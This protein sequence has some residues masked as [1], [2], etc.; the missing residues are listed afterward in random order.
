MIVGVAQWVGRDQD[1][2]RALD[3]VSI[4]E[5]VARDA[6]KDAGVGSRGLEALDRIAVPAIL[7][8]RVRNPAHRLAE[9]L[10]CHPR[11]EIRTSIGGNMPQRLVNET[12]R[13]VLEGRSE[14]ALIA[15]A[16]AQAS[17]QR[18]RRARIALDWPTSDEPERTVVGDRRPGA[19]EAETAH[20]I[21]LPAFVYPLF[22]NA[23]RARRG[24]SLAEHR[25]RLGRLCSRW[26][27]VAAENPYAWFPKRRSPEEITEPTAENRWIAFPY[28]KFMNAILAVDQGAALLL[29]SRG[30]ARAWGIPEERLVYWWGGGDAVQEPWFVSDRERFDASPALARAARGALAEA[31]VGVEELDFLDLYSCFPSSVEIACQELG[32][33]LDDPRPPTV[34]GGLP[35]AGGPGNNYTT[36]AVA[37]LVERLRRK[38]GARGLVTGLGWYLSRHS[39]GVYAS[40]PPER[41]EPRHPD[42]PAAGDFARPLDPDAAGEGRVETYTVLFARDGTPERGVVLGRLDGGRRFLAHTPSDPTL[43]EDLVRREVVGLRG[44]V[45]PGRPVNRFDPS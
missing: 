31:G 29:T 37:A 11:E 38:P 18:A 42:P 39:A 5:R 12:A 36:H 30:R 21:F 44:R 3:P 32:I 14:V 40:A 16:E 27:E 41:R 45:T 4:L 15:G 23:Y 28:T 19:N 6:A 2:R 26:T 25:E 33:G 34:T 9:R 22:E 7:S 1:P 20:G 10:G 35:Y 24:W 8:W 13:A 17:V 43:L